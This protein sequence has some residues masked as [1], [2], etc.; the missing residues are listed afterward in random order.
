[1]KIGR[2]PSPVRTG[3]PLVNELAQAIRK[4]ARKQTDILAAAGLSVNVFQFWKRG[5]HAPTL[6]SLAALAQV[7]GY[8]IT[9]QPEES[10]DE[11]S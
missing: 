3:L 11:Q 5:T 8:R 1:M 10:S 2:P 9:L 4:D 6:T 7:L